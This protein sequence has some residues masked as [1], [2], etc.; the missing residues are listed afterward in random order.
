MADYEEEE[1]D[2]LIET[3]PGDSDFVEEHG[4]ACVVQKVF[5]NQKIPNI[6]QRHQI[7]YSTGSVKVKFCDLI[8][9]NGSYENIVSKALVDYLKLDTKLYPHPYDTG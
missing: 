5:C 6:T 8:I 2:M 7:F 1:D 4:V 3:K 9:D